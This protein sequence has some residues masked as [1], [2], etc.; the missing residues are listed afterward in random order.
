MHHCRQKKIKSEG[1]QLHANKE[2]KQ[3]EVEIDLEKYNF[4]IWNKNK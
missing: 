2:N 4:K 3:D 1:E